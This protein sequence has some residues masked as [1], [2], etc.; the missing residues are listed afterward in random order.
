MSTRVVI[1]GIGLLTP[2]GLDRAST[3]EGIVA[4]RS[5]IDRITRFDAEAGGMTCTIAG[6]IKGFDP[7]AFINRKDARKMDTFIQYGVA[8]ANMALEHS[9]LEVSDANAERVGVI[10]GSGIGGLPSIEA[11]MEA[12]QKGGARKISPFFIPKTI[13]NMISGWVSMLTGA[14]GPNSATVTACATGTHAIGEAWR[15]IASG[16][17]DAMLAGGAES[18]I[19]ALGVGGFCASKALSTRN[20]DPQGASRP[21]DRDRDGFVM[22]EGAGV[23]V[24]ESLESARK[25]G[26]EII[27]E[28]VGYGMSGDAYHITAPAPGGEGGARCME[29]ALRSAGI[30]HD[31]VDYINAHGTSTPAGD[32][33]ETEG[34]KSV[35]GAHARK[36]MVTSNKSMIGH[37]LG[38]A[39]GVEAALTALS[40]QHGVAT[41]TIN[42]E[43]PGEGCDLDYIANE[44]RDA[45]IEVAIS[46]SFGFGGTNASVVLKKFS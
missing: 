26:A 1:T 3:W 23:L 17:A 5:G 30:P 46:N 8:A 10:I 24:L 34:I 40:I 11:T 38:A 9:G 31:R 22:G 32:L 41:P 42:L 16:E 35:F 19:C 25:R 39:G 28:I 2:L 12:Y 44:A 14:K 37:L 7:N 33:A 13:I 20:D 45:K 6:E 4:G 27:A 29:A 21:W 18:C 43:H 36:L 15:V